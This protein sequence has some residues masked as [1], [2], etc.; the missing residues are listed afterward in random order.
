M[1]AKQRRFSGLGL[2][3][4]AI[5]VIVIL[6]SAIL[7]GAL[8]YYTAKTGTERT[9]ANFSTDTAVN[10]VEQ[11]DVEGYQQFLQDQQETDLYWE[12]REEL[13]DIRVNAGVLYAYTLNVTDDKQIELLLDG[14]PDGSEDASEIGEL[15][16]VTTYDHVAPVLEGETSYSEIV[17]DPTYGDYLS[18]FAPIKDANGNVV[19]ILGVDIDAEQVGVISTNVIL[20]VLPILIPAILIFLVVAVG[21]LFMFIMRTVKPLQFVEEIAG[22]VADGDLAAAQ[23]SVDKLPVGRKDEIGQLSDSFRH[24]VNQLDNII[25]QIQTNSEQVAASSEE[26]YASAAQS[27]QANEH[28]RSLIEGV[29]TGSQN[30]LASSAEGVRG[31]EE[32]AEGAQQIAEAALSAS[33]SAGKTLDGAGLGQEAVDQIV[34]QMELIGKVTRESSEVIDRLDEHSGQIVNILDVITD[35]AEQTNLLALNAA[36][37]AARAGEHGKGFA[38]VADEIRHLADQ[39][40]QSVEEITNL[41]HTIQQDTGHAVSS[42]KTGSAETEAGLGIAKDTENRF[43][44][45][46]EDIQQVTNAIQDV[47]A[48]SEEMAAGSEE[49]TAVITQMEHIAQQAATHTKQVAADTESQLTA[50]EEISNASQGL[51]EIAQGLQDTIQQFKV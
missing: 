35:I 34:S 37:E 42:M 15:I 27:L 20:S 28:I 12:L 51:S 14:Q 24:M 8:I 21:A 11:M 30:Q 32:M 19:G 39:S 45:M 6:M 16:E 44:Q 7:N 2:K 1:K 13:D 43:L 18:A 22:Q 48:S 36:I 40:K 23:A 38:V 3:I 33:D 47:S 5:G 17:K 46:L 41:I 29:D 50:M 49:V 10:I 31:M 25:R 4:V 26:L 9:I